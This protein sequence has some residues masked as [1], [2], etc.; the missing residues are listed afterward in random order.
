MTTWN[1][2]WT[3]YYA[4]S[5]WGI[6]GE[7]SLENAQ[8][9]YNYLVNNGFTSNAAIGV[10]ANL[11]AESYVNPAQ[12]QV[13]KYDDGT[14]AE[15]YTDG[16]GFGLGMWTP[17]TKVSTYVGSESQS[18]MSD[19][20]KQMEYLVSNT[21][22]W[23]TYYVDE[24]GYSEYYGLTTI[25]FENMSEYAKSDAD[26]EDLAVAWAV[27][28]ER[29][30]STALSDGTVR[31][32]YATYFAEH[33][34]LSPEPTPETYT[35]SF[36]IVGSG[37]ATTGRESNTFSAGE[38]V[39]LYYTASTDYYFSGWSVVSGDATITG[40]RFT[41]P[42]S[43][44]VIRATF[45]EST[46]TTYTVTVNS[47][48]NGYAYAEPTTGLEGG[49]TIQLYAIPDN[50]SYFI[51]WTVISGDVT[52]NSDNTFTMP[53]SDVIIKAEF[54]KDKKKSKWWMYMRPSW[55]W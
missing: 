44:V 4:G 28:W 30:S 26:Y 16:Q 43:D 50:G 34:T 22:Q 12:W 11:Q 46:T 9:A 6:G 54:K 41:M 55:T 32:Q 14:Y 47:E 33:L 17:W 23:S 48:G 39:Y 42:A 13:I 40:N 45:I 2:N 49:E 27:Q 38:E 5:G 24:S 53:E 52:I 18:A 37:T 1:T 15:P 10:V 19:G 3:S 29:P 8:I 31:K 21:G 7:Y 20:D 25:R 36:E 35:V 51:G